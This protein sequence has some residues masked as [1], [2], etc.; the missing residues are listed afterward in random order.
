MVQQRGEHPDD[1]AV[2]DIGIMQYATVAER[3]PIADDRAML[4]VRVNYDIVLIM[5]AIG[6]PL[7]VVASRGLDRG[8]VTALPAATIPPARYWAWTVYL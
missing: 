6:I 4:R 1:A 8:K 5:V 2:A 3:H 7:D